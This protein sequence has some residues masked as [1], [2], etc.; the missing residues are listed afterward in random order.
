MTKSDAHELSEEVCGNQLAVISDQLA[1]I[2][3]QSFFS[4]F[5]FR[6]SQDFRQW[7]LHSNALAEVDALSFF[8]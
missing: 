3:E 4:V 8:L 2:G 7:L 1:V 5:G 6:M